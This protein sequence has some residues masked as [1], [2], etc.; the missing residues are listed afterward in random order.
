[1]ETRMAMKVPFGRNMRFQY[2][3][4]LQCKLGFKFI[5]RV[6]E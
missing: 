3:F 4:L 2:R 5:D 1:M 6:L